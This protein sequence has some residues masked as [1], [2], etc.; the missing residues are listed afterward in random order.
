[1]NVLL[2]RGACVEE[3]PVTGFIVDSGARCTSEV[4]ELHYREQHSLQR[5]M[6]SYFSNKM[7]CR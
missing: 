2:L 1:M 4:R 5:C 6:N 3:V 7:S